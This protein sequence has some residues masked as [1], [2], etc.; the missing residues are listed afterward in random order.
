MRRGATVG[1]EAHHV[2]AGA[3]IDGARGHAAAPAT[4]DRDLGGLGVGVDEQRARGGA[5]GALG[6]GDAGLDLGADAV[7][8]G[9]QRQLEADQGGGV[10]ARGGVVLRRDLAGQP[11]EQQAR[12][13][14]D[15]AGDDQ[16]LGDEL[17]DDVTLSPDEVTLSHEVDALLDEWIGTLTQREREVLEARYGLHGHN[18]E[19]LDVLSERLGLTR[20]RVRQVQNEALLKL[21]RYLGR[22]GI[23]QDKLI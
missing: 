23:T 14:L 1:L 5:G 2:I 7:D 10:G 3:D 11:P 21:K 13:Q 20:E 18:P 8:L 15:L 6:G 22:R 16:T 12:G 4:I 9:G 19:T 17:V